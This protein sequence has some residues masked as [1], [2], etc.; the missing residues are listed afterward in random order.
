[1]WRRLACHV[2]QPIKQAKV[3]LNCHFNR[4]FTRDVLCR[5]SKILKQVLNYVQ[6]IYLDPLK[7]NSLLG[8]YAG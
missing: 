2:H 5:L 8:A 6:V 7:K 4:I 1:M 3:H